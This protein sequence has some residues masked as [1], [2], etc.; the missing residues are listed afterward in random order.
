MVLRAC[1][2]SLSIISVLNVRSGELYPPAPYTFLVNITRPKSWQVKKVCLRTFTKSPAKS[3]HI[4]IQTGVEINIL[5][6]WRHPHAFTSSFEENDTGRSAISVR[7]CLPVKNW[8]GH[9]LLI[10]DS[11]AVLLTL[12]AEVLEIVGKGISFST[13]RVVYFESSAHR[14]LFCRNLTCTL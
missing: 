7:S 4:R 13:E 1:P 8:K 9:L 3:T 10:T 11:Y 12:K 6:H 5:M 14:L 2:C